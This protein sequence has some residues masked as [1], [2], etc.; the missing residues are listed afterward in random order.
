NVDAGLFE[1]RQHTHQVHCCAGTLRHDISVPFSWCEI[2]N[3]VETFCSSTK[4]GVGELRAVYN[5]EVG[6]R[7]FDDDD[8]DFLFAC[9]NFGSRKVARSNVVVVPETEV[10]HV[11][12]RKELPD[13]R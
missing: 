1:F 11:A 2:A 6:P 7:D 12:A 3:D 10:D 13:L 4:V 5:L 9:C 8:S